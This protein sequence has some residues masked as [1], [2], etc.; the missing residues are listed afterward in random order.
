MNNRTTQ[1]IVRFQSAFSLPGFDAPQPPGEYLVD[2]DEEPIEIASHLA[3]RRVATFI[4]LPAISTVCPTQ[5]MVPIDPA[6]LDAALEQ[7]QKQS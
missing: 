1:K 4:H 7:D 3:W 2:H 6:F 5:Q